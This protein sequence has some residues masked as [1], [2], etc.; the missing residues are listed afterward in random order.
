MF[1]SKNY[2]TISHWEDILIIMLRVFLF[3]EPRWI[4][5][6]GLYLREDGI[7]RL[8]FWN[9][10]INDKELWPFGQTIMFTDIPYLDMLKGGNSKPPLDMLREA[11]LD[12]TKP[13]AINAA[14]K[15]FDQ[16]V[17]QLQELIDK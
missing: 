2:M 7:S 13:E 4:L 14:L 12:L 8:F 3:F 15:L 10:N 6:T 5:E 17:D 1:T 9:R 16:T 11:G